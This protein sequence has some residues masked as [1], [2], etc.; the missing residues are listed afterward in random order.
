MTARQ[1]IFSSERLG[2]DVKKL[3]P[4]ITPGQS[5]TA[6]WTTPLTFSWAT[7]R[8]LPHA[9]MMLIPEVWGDHVR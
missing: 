4:V 2:D 3:L 5:D 8:S 7:G 9:M 1:S 6:S